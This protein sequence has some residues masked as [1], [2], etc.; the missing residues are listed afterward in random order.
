MQENIIDSLV[1]KIAAE[2][3]GQQSAPAS[4]ASAPK[5]A[6]K[7][8]AQPAA[9]ADGK[10]TVADYP[11][12]EKHR[13]I[14]KTPTGKNVGDITLDA[15]VKGNVEIEDVRISAEMLRNQA[16]IAESAGKKQIAQ[17]LRR[18]AEMTAI[19]D[20]VVIKMYDMLRPHR[21]T[22]EQLLEM[23]DTLRNKYH[24]QKLAEL[25][26]EACAVY[27]KRGILLK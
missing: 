2:V 22:K 11:L 21:A 16:D 18:A 25:V 7:A 19:E 26:S 3:K 13:D 10:Y 4:K 15:L 9:K 23:A 12:M 5:E 24:A 27:E 14:I 17:N 8:A 20:D 1:A 6:P